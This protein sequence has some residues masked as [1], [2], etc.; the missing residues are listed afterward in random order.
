VQDQEV[1]ADYW[2]TYLWYL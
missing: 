2:N 1:Q